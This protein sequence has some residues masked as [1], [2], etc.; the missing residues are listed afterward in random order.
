MHDAAWW[1]NENETSLS[2]CSIS[3]GME[4]LAAHTLPWFD[5]CH[6]LC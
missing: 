2:A 6:R 4:K 3:L 5:N 1:P